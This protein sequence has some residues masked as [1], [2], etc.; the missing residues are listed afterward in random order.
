MKKFFTSAL[1]ATTM[2]T[3]GF[4]QQCGTTKT[5]ANG[6]EKAGDKVCGF[7]PKVCNVTPDSLKTFGDKI[8]YSFGLQLAKQIKNMKKDVDPNID[9]VISNEIVLKGILHGVLGEK[10][11]LSDTQVHQL[12][13][14]LQQRMQIAQIKKNK[15]MRA[16]QAK[17]GES[18]LVAGKKFL[19]ENKKKEGV[20]TTPSGLQYKVLRSADGEK[21][22]ATDTVEVHYKGTTIDGK[23]FDSSYARGQKVSFP[24]NRVI[25]GWTEG[26]QLMNVGSKYRFFIPS[27]L[28][29]GKRGAGAA[30]PPNS[31]LIF[32]V[33]LFSIK[34]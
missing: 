11:F 30:V 26:L 2:V 10:P 16:K 34:K 3:Q 25:K 27:E 1:F 21:P 28:A 7:I 14:E 15:E 6:C 13:T 31:T 20:K 9:G 23:V 19:E 32:D 17:A 33:E 29:Y 4:S 24:L 22:K 8:S 12:I 5:P 18:A